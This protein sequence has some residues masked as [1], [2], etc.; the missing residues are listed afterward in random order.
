MVQLK[1]FRCWYRDGTVQLVDE[2]SHRQ[3]A[4]FAQGL[5]ETR[6]GPAPEKDGS[7]MARYKDAVRVRRTECLTDG[8]ECK[9][10]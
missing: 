3:A 1:I 10:K 4:I 2:K 7:E 6:Q 5:A 9:W 8:T